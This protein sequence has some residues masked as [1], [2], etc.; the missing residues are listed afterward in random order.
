ML[1][2]LG[3][4]YGFRG[5][6]ADLRPADRAASLRNA[7]R[8]LPRHRT[9][10]LRQLRASMDA[11]PPGLLLAAAAAAALAWGAASAAAGLLALGAADALAQTPTDPFARSDAETAVLLDFLNGVAGGER[12]GLAEMLRV[13][14][15]AVLIYAGLL[16]LWRLVEAAVETART[17]RSGIGGW[18]AIRFAGALALIAPMPASGL[19]GAQLLVLALAD[20]GGRAA[21]VV[22]EPFATATLAEGRIAA[23]VSLPPSYRPALGAALLSE[24]C[25]RVLNAEAA[26]RG[27][28]PWVERR[29][30]TS[31]SG[32]RIGYDGTRRPM[33]R[34]LL[35][36]HPRGGC[37][38]IRFPVPDADGGAAAAAAEAHQL[39]FAAI[40]PALR[41]LADEVA[42]SYVE[43]H[44]AHGRA[45]PD[46]PG[47]AAAIER[48]YRA[49]A[50]TRLAAAAAA[51]AAA[52]PSEV[53]AAIGSEG[54]IAAA[55]YFHLIFR[56]NVSLLAAAAGA[57]GYIL[58]PDDLGTRAPDAAAAVQHAALL[59]QQT[60][61]AIAPVDVRA[62]G[63]SGA[64][65]LLGSV[66]RFADV[67]SVR[68]VDSGAPLADLASL[69]Q[70]LINLVV[71]VITALTGAAAGSGFASAI[72]LIGRGLDAFGHAW[73]VLDGFVTTALMIL[74]LVGGVLAY[75][76][77]AT[78]FIRFLFGILAWVLDIVE[79]I[80]AVPLWAAA[81]VA[82][83]RDQL[84]PSGVRSGWLLLL[85]IV[86]RPALMILGLV[87]GYLA[88]AAGVR[89]LNRL[90]LPGITGIEGEPTVSPLSWAVYL[91][92]YTLI[93]WGMANTAFQAV[94]RLPA[95]ILRWIGVAAGHEPAG[96]R[97]G[98]SI[99]GAAG[100]ASSMA[101][102]AAGRLGRAFRK[103][104]G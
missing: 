81:H 88:F 50:E 41:D 45:V 46:L 91:V 30:S 58:P 61:L 37:G 20:M 8:L 66:F 7:F 90:W 85:G 99:A 10:P 78:P 4:V 6:L 13:F 76:I 68:I 18:D 26:A 11:G 72:P 92:I 3:T 16:T 80:A 84:I 23:P 53:R 79:A 82:R 62:A 49:E 87:L 40:D 32:V 59:V 74:T 71:G 75:L 19:G 24:V 77:P 25:M 27:E 14:N 69:G 54:W 33:G 98:T 103:D 89:L 101:G 64:G 95:A 102:G 12:T 104:E 52:R 67:D 17:G 48:D 86:L 2:T 1:R 31:P 5:V 38:E 93:V 83:G 47:R 97:V 70:T 73:R 43:G 29:I 44:P 21:S 36:S 22:W 51:A 42:A 96:D 34:F 35:P 55:T 63:A 28:T 56:S 65:T 9:P 100:R 60:D 94:D 15:A 39:A 57:P